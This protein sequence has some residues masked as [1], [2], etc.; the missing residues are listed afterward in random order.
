M[1]HR[2]D[3]VYEKGVFRPVEPVTLDEGSR[4]AIEYE[5]TATSPDPQELIQALDSI[6]ALPCEGPD[7]G[8][9]AVD[10][11]RVLYGGGDAR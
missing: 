3:A 9:S 8:F 2:V 11:D 5:T 4:V 1:T 6:A 7:D 10:A